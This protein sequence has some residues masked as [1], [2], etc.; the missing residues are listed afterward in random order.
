MHAVVTPFDADGALDEPAFVSNVATYLDQGVSGI[1]LAGDN[2]E[3]WSLSDDEKVRLTVLTRELI[4]AGG[5]RAKLVVGANAILTS[6][7]IETTR[8]VADAGADAVLVG[9][10]THLVTATQNEIIQRFESVAARGR[11]PIVLYNNPRRTQVNLTSD[12][13]DR[14]ADVDGVVGLKDSGQDLSQFTA[15]LRR[16]RDRINVMLG[17]CYFIFPAVLLGAAGYISSGPDLLGKRGVEYFARLVAGDVTTTGSTHFQ[18]QRVSAAVSAAGTFP[19]GLK[20]AMEL[21][22]MRGGY[23]RAPI[24]PVSAEARATLRQ[25]LVDAGVLEGALVTA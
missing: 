16:T 25:A 10:A 5:R 23:P 12:L 11:L 7:V 13:V 19:A 8:R 2:G 4:D 14:L 9:P 15:T 24:L 20:A 22:G 21:V 18:L 1:V 3:G 6:G 17:P